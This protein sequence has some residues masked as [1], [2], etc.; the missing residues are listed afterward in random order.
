MYDECLAFVYPDSQ[1]LCFTTDGSVFFHTTDELLDFI[2]KKCGKDVVDCIHF[3][4]ADTAFRTLDEF[5]L[6]KYEEFVDSDESMNPILK[7]KKLK[8]MLNES[9]EVIRGF[10]NLF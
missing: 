7:I 3:E 8:E 1:K 2:E 5:P 9:L 6:D 10:Y 4:S